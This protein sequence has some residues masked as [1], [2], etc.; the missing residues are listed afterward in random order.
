[1]KRHA[2]DFVDVLAAFHHVEDEFVEIFLLFCER[3]VLIR[4]RF[5]ARKFFVSS[6]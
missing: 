4:Q 1:M 6:S 5:F 2:E 3:K